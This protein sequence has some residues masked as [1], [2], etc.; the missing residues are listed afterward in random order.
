MMPNAGEECGR[1]LCVD[2]VPLN[3]LF[4]RVGRFGLSSARSEKII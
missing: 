4:E 1:G 3:I 2:L